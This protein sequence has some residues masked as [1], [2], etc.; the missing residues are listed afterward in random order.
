MSAATKARGVATVSNTDGGSAR[1]KTMVKGR[2]GTLYHLSSILEE[3]QK[4]GTTTLDDVKIRRRFATSRYFLSPAGI[5]KLLVIVSTL[6]FSFT[7]LCPLHVTQRAFVGCSQNTE[8]L[9]AMKV[10]YYRLGV[11]VRITK[12]PVKDVCVA[13]ILKKV[14]TGK[15]RCKYASD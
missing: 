10:G 2:R 9:T 5:L 14:D 13:E 6:R 12:F 3:Q 15:G 8:A 4:G 1:G 7:T 11:G